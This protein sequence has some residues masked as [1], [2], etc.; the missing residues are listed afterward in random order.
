MEKQ[1]NSGNAHDT[2]PQNNNICE[3]THENLSAILS[4]LKIPR[5]FE[6]YVEEYDE[7]GGPNHTPVWKPIRVDPTLGGNGG[8]PVITVYSP[9][10]LAEKR[11]FYSDIGQRFKIIREI[12]PPT[13]DMI[14]EYAEKQG[15][16]IPKSAFGNNSTANDCPTQIKNENAL[17]QIASVRQIQQNAVSVN[18]VTLQQPVTVLRQK[19]KIVT[20]GDMQIKYDGD[21]VYQMQWV[22]LNESEAANYRIVSDS[23]NK[24]LP[25]KNRHIEA[26]RWV[27][28]EQ[29]QNSE[30]EAQ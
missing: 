16:N 4:N 2:I 25:M 27:M 1:N 15:I 14:I 29:E 20:I 10:D 17:T 22:R 7:E 26:K 18:N 9:A 3:V 24:I 28:V 19:P 23:S 13:N 8:N 11:K 30:T 5:K 12:D 21:N 6:I